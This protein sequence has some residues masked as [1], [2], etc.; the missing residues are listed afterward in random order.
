[1]KLYYSEKNINLT[2][3]CVKITTDLT[4]LLLSTINYALASISS[5]FFFLLILLT[6][7]INLVNIKQREVTLPYSNT[8]IE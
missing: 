8:K 4:M 6:I 2:S 7:V 1:M 5:S 3:N